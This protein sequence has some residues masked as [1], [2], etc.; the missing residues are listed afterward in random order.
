MK[1]KKIVIGLAV[2]TALFISSEISAQQRHSCSTF[3]IES[4]DTIITGHN[5]DDYFTV[6]GMVVVNPRGIEKQSLSWKDFRKG[7]KND[8]PRISWK[9]KYGS[10]TYSIFGRELIDGGMNEAG[11]YIGEMTLFK[12]KYPT[13]SSQPTFYHCFFMQYILDNFS[14]VDEALESF[15][16]L[17]IDGHSLW[18]FFIA[19][20]HGNTAIVEFLNGEPVV[21]RGENLPH[22]VLCNTT[23]QSDLDSLALYKGYGGERVIDVTD[24]ENTKRTVRATEMIR[25]YSEN[26]QK[27]I[28]DYS[29]EMLSLLDLG[30]NQ[31]QIVCDLTNQRVYFRTVLNGNIKFVDFSD[32]DF[33]S[34]SQ[35]YIDIHS[36]QV[37]D[38]S[39]SF[40]TLTN[41]INKK[42]VRKTWWAIDM[43]FFGNIFVKPFAVW[44]FGGRMSGY[45]SDF[46]SRNK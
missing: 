42:Y 16:R 43:G 31:W 4:G 9:S 5:L 32:F 33:S 45:T 19:D 41:K 20:K 38:V 26:Q 13:I 14:S 40:Q 46:Y 10:I 27:P 25:L 12:T 28:I 39:A 29:F 11:L 17:N 34:S 24:K 36:N 35:K 21:Y 30:N 2:I 37:G 23:Y 8:V 6:P 44:M 18:H 3:Q 1:A 22:K 15:S 7:R